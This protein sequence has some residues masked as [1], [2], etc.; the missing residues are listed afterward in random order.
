MLY[1]VVCCIYGVMNCGVCCVSML[2][3]MLLCFAYVVSNSAV[4]GDGHFF[5]KKK[6]LGII[7]L[8]VTK[9]GSGLHPA[10]IYLF[11]AHNGN[12]RTMCEIWSKFK[13][14]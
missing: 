13:M 6:K 8:I 11:K 3:C 1:C 12:I 9:H 7:C 4:R 5:R 2:F 14:L 10:G